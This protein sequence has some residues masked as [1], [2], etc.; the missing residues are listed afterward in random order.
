MK[1]WMKIVLGILLVVAIGVVGYF[2]G[3]TPPAIV[4]TTTVTLDVRPSP[5]FT[6]AV[7][8]ATIITYP[9]R[10][11]AFDA[12]CTGVNNFAGVVTLTISDLPAGATA[13]F[14]PSATFTLGTEPLGAQ[15]NITLPDNQAL[16]GLHTLTITA[17]STSYN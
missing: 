6:L 14:L 3:Q 1:T 7:T 2:I 15:I 13:Q 8:P 10:T 17:T 11:V 5:T 9:N 12:L 4:K 16:V